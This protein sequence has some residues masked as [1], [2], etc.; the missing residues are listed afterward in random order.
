M[1]QQ[2]TFGKKIAFGFA[3]T[4]LLAFLI[5]AVS[6]YAIVE[7]AKT[8]DQVI[9]V[10]DQDTENAMTLRAMIDK[11]ISDLRGVLLTRAKPNENEGNPKTESKRALKEL[12]D[13]PDKQEKPMVDKFTSL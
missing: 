3:V 7:V 5:A 6:T 13:H 1:G 4:V 8:K 12:A 9:T 10:S 11:Q 2:W